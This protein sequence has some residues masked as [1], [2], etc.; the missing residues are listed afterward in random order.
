M[1]TSAFRV[2][3]AQRGAFFSPQMCGGEMPCPSIALLGEMPCPPMALVL[4]NGHGIVQRRRLR[5]KS[6]EAT[7]RFLSIFDQ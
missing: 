4:I 7:I 6:G 1:R 3:Y 5:L 2:R